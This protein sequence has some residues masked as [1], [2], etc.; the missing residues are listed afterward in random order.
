MVEVK[1]KPSLVGTVPDGSVTNAKVAANAAIEK[2]KL[3]ALE[4]VNADVATGAAIAK[5][6]LAALAIVNDDVDAAAGIVKTKLAALAIVDADVDAAAAIAKTKLAALAIEDD[7]VSGISV[8]KVADAVAGTG[9][10][11][12]KKVIKL[13]WDSTTEEVI[14]DHEA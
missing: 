5:A 6:K 1:F 9:T 10:S 2:T 7:D 4:I 8:S 13:G 3:A 14:V 11:G 12:N